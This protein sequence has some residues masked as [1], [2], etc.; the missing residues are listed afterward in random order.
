[1]HKEFRKM[2]RGS[3]YGRIRCF[4]VASCE[5]LTKATP[6]VQVTVLLAYIMPDMVGQFV[7]RSS[8]QACRAGGEEWGDDEARIVLGE[9]GGVALRIR[10]GFRWIC[11]ECAKQLGNAVKAGAWI[12]SSLKYFLECANLA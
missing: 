9:A 12:F 2:F 10:S 8:G 4:L 3:R 7:C 5:S 11:V 1:M 6:G